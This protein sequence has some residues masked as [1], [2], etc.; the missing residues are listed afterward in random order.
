MAT[1]KTP[2]SSKETVAT[3]KP[4]TLKRKVTPKNSINLKKV[5]P[6]KIKKVDI[7]PEAK[8]VLDTKNLKDTVKTAVVSIRQVKWKYPEDVNGPL[9]R[10]A[11]RG[12]QRTKLTKMEA[13]ITTAESDKA[14]KLNEKA[15]AEYRKEVLLVP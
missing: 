15:L 6:V 2:V 14:K 11:W 13:A 4:V 3:T 8:K 12:V 7:E 5:T 9:D 10:K 1:M